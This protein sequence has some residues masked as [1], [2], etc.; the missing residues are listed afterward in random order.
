MFNPLAQSK[1]SNQAEGV[2]LKTSPPA[3]G[4]NFVEDSRF[5]AG[6]TIGEV[7]KIYV[8]SDLPD[9]RLYCWI[10]VNPATAGENI[11]G[12]VELLQNNTLITS[13]P[14]RMLN[15][16]SATEVPR[17][18]NIAFGLNANYWPPFEPALS[19][20]VAGLNQTC[21]GV[22]FRLQ[23]DTAK[24]VL[25]RND[26]NGTKLVALACLSQTL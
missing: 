17:G 19:I 21:G 18:F 25:T 5:I 11:I 14:V 24:L 13:L 4:L 9:R 8:P 12:R 10:E 16:S 2:S 20:C 7:A 22:P 23:F 26:I 3:L 15:T 1:R 6:Q